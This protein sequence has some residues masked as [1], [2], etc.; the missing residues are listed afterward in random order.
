M[1]WALDASGIV[2]VEGSLEIDEKRRVDVNI[3]FQPYVNQ[4]VDSN[5]ITAFY[6]GK[7]ANPDKPDEE[8]LKEI[9]E[10]FAKLL[11]LIEQIP[12]EKFFL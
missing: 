7:R 8:I 12:N 10:L 1:A 3:S 11:G 5:M 4:I 2:W 6:T 9:F